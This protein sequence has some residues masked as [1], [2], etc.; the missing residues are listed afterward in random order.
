M[1]RLYSLPLLFLSLLPCFLAAQTG[2]FQHKKDS[3]YKI[4]LNTKDSVK[5]EAYYDLTSFLYF[6]EQNADSVLKYLYLNE[7]EAK[8]Q[9]NLNAQRNVRKNIGGLLRN[10]SLYDKFLDRAYDDLAFMEKHE[11]WE[12]YYDLTRKIVESYHYV[13]RNKEALNAATEFYEQAKRRN[14]PEGIQ[15][16]LYAIGFYYEANRRNA[17]AEKYFRMSLDEANRSGKVTDI[18]L[19]CYYQLISTLINHHKWDECKE[20]FPQWEADTKEREKDDPR[21]S[22]SFYLNL[23][24]M[25]SHYYAGIEDADQAEKYC[26]LLEEKW[27]ESMIAHLVSTTN[28]ASIY[29][30]RKDWA[31]M[32]E[33]AEKAYELH[34]KYN[35][36][37]SMSSLSQY[38]AKALNYLGRADECYAEIEH[39]TILR[40][41]LANQ[42][43]NAQLDE[44]RTQYEVDKHI[45]EKQRNRN[46]FL[47]AL[48]G[49]ILL[50]VALGIWVY[51]SR[52]IL[53]KNR[54]LVR[55]AQQWANVAPVPAIADT[56]GET[57]PEEQLSKT[58]E[59]DET[60]RLLF[61]EI[62]QLIDQGLFKESNLSLDMLAGK[63]NQNPTYISKAIS[64]CTG[65]TFKT[66]LNEY[67]IEEAVRLLSDE[68]N[69]NISIETVA[70]DSGFNDRKTFHR[71]FRHTTGLSPT[72]FKKN[73]LRK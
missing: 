27:P 7:R 22:N 70:W 64:R 13:G 42:E 24:V 9:N 43:L 30:T 4:V 48:G 62:E 20:L 1:R 58:P 72:D 36:L 5:L 71:I 11:F 37:L 47:F 63:T 28:R 17:E 35:S 21:S 31:K 59:P 26:R 33:Y 65:K 54:E 68:N 73:G 32:L 16:T 57:E 14:H 23:Y 19:T 56:D 39:Y 8:K 25:Y 66:W 10:R 69:P 67:R 46:Y 40:D 3:L 6:H 38:K 44:L 2:D 49:C 29:Q 12:Y 45:A 34:E 55:K 61:A 51:Y 60:D 18:K 52:Q 41:S 15:S 53:H 50:A